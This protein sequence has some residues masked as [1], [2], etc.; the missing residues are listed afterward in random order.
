MAIRSIRWLAVLLAL[1]PSLALGQIYTKLAPGTS[2]TKRRSTGMA[3]QP[4]ATGER[5]WAFGGFATAGELSDLWAYDYVTATDTGNWSSVAQANTPAKR[6]RHGLSWAD[7]LSR[8]VVFGGITPGTSCPGQLLP[9]LGLVLLPLRRAGVRPDRRLVDD[10]HPER[11]RAC[12]PRRRRLLLGAPPV[13]LPDVLGHEDHA[14]AR[15]GDLWSL[16]I[17]TTTHAATWT[18]LSPTGTAPSARTA[19]CWGYDA[20][21]HVLIVFGGD[22]GGDA[23]PGP[24]YVNDTY[25][26]DV[27]SNVWTKD[28]PTGSIPAARA[29][30]MCTFDPTAQRLVLH[31]GASNSLGSYSPDDTCTYDAVAQKWALLSSSSTL[32]KIS[33]TSQVFSPVQKK[34]FLFGGDTRPATSTARGRCSSTARLSRTRGRIRASTSRR[35]SRS[36]AASRLTPTATPSPTRG[37]S[38]PGPPSRSRRPPRRSRPSHLRR[39]PPPRRSPSS[40]SST[41]A[42]PARRPTPSSSTSPTP[43]MTRRSRT[44]GPTSRSPRAPS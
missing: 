14:R 17:N 3:L 1:V 5:Y 25:E 44:R 19:V 36:T 10:V 38:C 20:T 9:V 18:L 28:T 41:T 12:R 22:P 39:S 13:A 34:T 6:D 32:G 21:R 26:Y 29:F 23:I 33:D 30:S 42:R 31:S 2:P 24:G 11:S 15:R 37:A 16:T 40:S 4:L 7:S 27:D 8:L 35:S 43:S